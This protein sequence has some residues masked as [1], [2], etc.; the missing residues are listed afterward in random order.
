M[1]IS[2]IKQGLDSGMSLDVV[3]YLVQLAI[4]YQD[5]GLTILVN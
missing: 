4:I 5:M 2:L 3:L 1:I